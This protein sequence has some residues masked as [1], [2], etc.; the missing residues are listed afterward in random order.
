MLIAICVSHTVF[1][2]VIYCKVDQV[3]QIA[4]R[5]EADDIESKEARDLKEWE[6][7]KIG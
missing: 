4:K 7:W 6:P 1:L 3:W 5:A 2:W